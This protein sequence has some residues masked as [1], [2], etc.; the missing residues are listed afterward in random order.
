M[1]PNARGAAAGVG[2]EGGSLGWGKGWGRD[3]ACSAEPAQGAAD[4]LCLQ[5]GWGE[6]KEHPQMG[7][8][9]SFPSA[10]SALHSLRLECNAGAWGG[11]VG[12]GLGTIANVRAAAELWAR[13]V[14]RRQPGNCLRQSYIINPGKGCIH[15]IVPCTA[16]ICLTKRIRAMQ[17]CK[18]LCCKM[19]KSL[20]R[21]SPAYSS[22]RWTASSLSSG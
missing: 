3:S 8:C 22:T 4:L 6:C 13:L 2:G 17:S 21:S 12:K 11:E 18:Q 15:R 10:S 16:L 1:H 5:R 14:H 19:Q 20:L 7:C 9:S